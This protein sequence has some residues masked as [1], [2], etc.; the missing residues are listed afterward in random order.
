MNGAKTDDGFLRE[1]RRADRAG[2][3][4]GFLSNER[5]E[6][7]ELWMESRGYSMVTHR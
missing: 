3:D 4:I 7:R 6:M 5:V 1:M 2:A